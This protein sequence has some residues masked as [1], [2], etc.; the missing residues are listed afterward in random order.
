MNIQYPNPIA[1]IFSCLSSLIGEELF[2][3]GGSTRDLLLNREVDDLDFATSADPTFIH[4]LFPDKLYFEKFGTTTFKIE[5][6]HITLA[7]YRRESDYTDFRH[8]NKVEFLKDY[9]EDSRRRDFTINALYGSITGEIL[10]PTGNGLKDIA[11]KRIRIIGDPNVR[12]KE[13]P[14]R[15][16][17]AFRFSEELSFTLDESLR[18]AIK[19][20]EELL[21]MLSPNKIMEEIRKFPK[22]RQE[23]YL[24]LY[25][26]SED[27][28]ID[29]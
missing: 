29:I 21:S 18:K 20:D 9:K 24:T 23:H 27:S 1:S 13:D 6:Y 5:K 7:S 10:D 26:H 17:R 12:L 8:P 28:S 19:E 11:E 2:L 15:I 4:A 22:E 14:L 25:Y 3:V 16:L